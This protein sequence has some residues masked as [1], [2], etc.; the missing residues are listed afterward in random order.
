MNPE[1]KSLIDDIINR[2]TSIFNLNSFRIKLGNFLTTKYNKGIERSEIQFNMNFLPNKQKIQFLEN[3]TFD[4]IEGVTDDLVKNLRGEIQRGIMNK[5]GID[6]IKLRL[7]KVFKG[8]NPTR[9]R[10][11]DRLKMIAKTETARAEAMGQFDGAIQ[12]G[13]EVKKY[14]LVHK[15]DRTSGICSGLHKKYGELKQAIE[16]DEEFTTEYKGKTYSGLTNPFHPNCRTKV[17]Y[18]PKE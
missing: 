1:V 17:L 9:F 7:D 2:V 15:D 4:L 6:K 16:M 13:V 8:D 14:L 3:Y 10:Y 11:E 5:E 18:T 12:S